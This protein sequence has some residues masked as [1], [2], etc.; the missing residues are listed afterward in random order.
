MTKRA[1]MIEV[2]Y[3]YIVKILCLALLDFAFAA[4]VI[5][6]K[7]QYHAKKIFNFNL[8]RFVKK[9][10]HWNIRNKI[11]VGIVIIIFIVIKTVISMFI[12]STIIIFIIFIIILFL[13]LLILFLLLSYD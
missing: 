9:H 6:V 5:S 10:G 8:S 4:T 12:I 11:N 3:S 1:L 7:K 13:F 2:Y